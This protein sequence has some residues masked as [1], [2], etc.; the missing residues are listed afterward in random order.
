MCAPHYPDN[1]FSG[2]TG[3]SYVPKCSYL[4]R[5]QA[6][7]SWKNLGINQSFASI[8]PVVKLY[9]REEKPLPDSVAHEPKVYK[10]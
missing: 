2:E 1:I 9:E 6:W 8:V 4:E 5:N 10:E 3:K 7:A